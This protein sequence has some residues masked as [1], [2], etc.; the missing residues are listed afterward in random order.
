VAERG[1]QL[2]ATLTAFSSHCF[3][4]P[5]ERASVIE[6]TCLGNAAVTDDYPRPGICSFR[7]VSQGMLRGAPL[8]RPNAQREIRL[9][10]PFTYN[11]ARTSRVILVT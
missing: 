2:T 9:T 10:Y 11:V 7:A 6:A 3:R 8:L 1:R 4:Q 5:S